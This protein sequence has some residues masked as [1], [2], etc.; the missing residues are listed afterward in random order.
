M[1][2]K[3][4]N[5]SKRANRTKKDM[6][7]PEGLGEDDAENKQQ[8]SVFDKFQPPVTYIKPRG[9]CWFQTNDRPSHVMDTIKDEILGLKGKILKENAD[10]FE[11]D[12]QFKLDFKPEKDVVVLATINLYT[13]QPE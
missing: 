11:M 9:A 10:E 12:V 4:F 2:H 6:V 3:K 8:E 1:D 5:E 13:V 7:L